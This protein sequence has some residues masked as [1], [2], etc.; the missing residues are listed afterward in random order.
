MSEGRRRKVTEED[1]LELLGE[2]PGLTCTEVGETLWP[3]P[4]GNRPANARI[5]GKMLKRLVSSGR[6]RE[7][8]DVSGAYRRTFWPEPRR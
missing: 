5:A 8:I 1:V 4:A 7:K 3:S 6:V 2:R